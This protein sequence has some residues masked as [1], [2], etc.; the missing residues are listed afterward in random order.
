MGKIGR[1]KK[2]ICM[3]GGYFSLKDE[4]M[5]RVMF[6]VGGV[7]G[8]DWMEGEYLWRREGREVEYVN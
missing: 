5:K 8:W 1:K 6:L 3:F 4:S 7:L 2:E